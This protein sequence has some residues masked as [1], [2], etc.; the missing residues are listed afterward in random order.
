MK[1]HEAL[2]ID[3][4]EINREIVNLVAR[5]KDVPKKSQLAQSVLE[6]INSGGK[7][8]RPLMVIVG[9]RFGRKDT[10]RRA[11]QLA[12]AAE[13]IHAASL[14]HDDIID[15]SELRRGVPALH[16]K[17]GTLSAVHVGN[18]MSARVIELLSKYTGD[19]NRYVHDLSSVATAQLCLGE[20]QQM[21][22][23]F[24]YEI[25]MDQY[26]EKSLNKTALL[27]A[28]CLRVGALSTE[29]TEEVANLLYNFGEALGMS[30][31]IQDD[32]LDFTQSA[33]VL[34]KP[35]GS[36]LRHG[37]VTLPVL[38][39]LQDPKL[40]PV[41]R[42]I[43]PDSSD[44]EVAYVLTLINNSDALARAERV[45]QNYLDKAAAIVQQLSSYPAHAD[46]ETLLQYF[47]DRDR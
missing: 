26:L 7:R 19:K 41:I 40:S 8:L 33:D 30:F 31:Q 43:G 37:Q 21:E 14:I 29:S 42:A 18:Y 22:H 46:L 11:L 24:D 15:R 47:A 35:A 17:T 16:I 1:L 38:Y 10:G 6:L 39:A 2:N 20:Y 45:S 12:A 4:N 27:M 9:S 44:A 32:L 36:D 3:I 25:T 23:A 13:F 28:T 34:G 5:D